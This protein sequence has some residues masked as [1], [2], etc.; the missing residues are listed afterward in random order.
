MSIDWSTVFDEVHDKPA[1]ASDAEI[2][3][4]IRT[5]LQPLSREE[6]EWI[7]NPWPKNH[8]KRGSYGPLGFDPAGWCL[9]S[10]PLPESY[11]SLLRWCNG[12]GF[13]T[14]DRHFQF[15]SALEGPNRVRG[16]MLAYHVPQWL[17]GALPIAFNGSGTFYLIDMRQRAVDNE[18]PI[19]CSNAS[20][21]GWGSRDHA[22][23]AAS[24]EAACRGTFDVDDLL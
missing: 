20:T 7:N 22:V 14:R 24:L 5:V 16:M 21:L 15:F 2:Q 23:V 13:S 12:G 4:F 9:P 19:V 10:Q 18:Y 3:E 11:L 1:G 17:P 6:V 8:P